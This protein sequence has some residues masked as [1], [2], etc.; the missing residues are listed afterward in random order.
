MRMWLI[1]S[2]AAIGFIAAIYGYGQ[3]KATTAVETASYSAETT[4]MA[5]TPSPPPST[6]GQGGA[7]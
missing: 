5:S 7:R 4:G 2:I 1:A 3:Y 6:T